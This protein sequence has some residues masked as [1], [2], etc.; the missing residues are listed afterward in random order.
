MK[1]ILYIFGILFLVN[2][3]PIAIGST[4]YYVSPTGTDTNN[5]TSLSTP[6]KTITNALNKARSSGDTVYVMTGSYPET[7]S[8]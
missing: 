1:K 2:Q 6:V 4:I 7:V 3:M 8:I 5:G